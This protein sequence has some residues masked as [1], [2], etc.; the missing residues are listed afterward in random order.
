MTRHVVLLRGINFGSHRRIAMADLRALLSGAGH[1]DV[2]THLQSGNVVL[3]SRESAERVGELVHEQI[4][5][6][7]GM[8]VP[9]LVRTRDEIDGVVRRNP[10]RDVADDFR[11]LQVSFLS[12][13]LAPGVVADLEAVDLGPERLAIGGRELYAWHP[14]G[15]QAS[16]LARMLVDRR[17]GVTATARNWSTVTRL[18]E[19][20]D[21]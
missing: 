3:T 4:R 12:A 1:A 8:D 20:A 17:L 19:L 14:N 5:D 15:I 13:E 9:V 2:R 18:L 21:S 10:L 16:P 11:R 7:L 6:G